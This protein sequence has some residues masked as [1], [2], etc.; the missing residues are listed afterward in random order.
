VSLAWGLWDQ[1]S[2]MTGGL[3][4]ADRAR[5]ARTGVRALP[6]DEALAQLDRALAG[7]RA[8][9]VPI[10]LDVRVLRAAGAE[11]VA[12]VLRALVP[13]TRPVSQARGAAEQTPP[14]AGLAGAA[15]REALLD[16]VCAHVATV[17]GHASADDVE[18]DRGFADLGFDSLM[19]VELRN[20]LAAV[21]GSRLRATL[22]FDFPT[23]D[24]LAR[25]LDEELPGEQPAGL[26]SA[27]DELTRLERAVA[28]L[29]DDEA[30]RTHL[31]GRLRALLGGLTDAAEVTERPSVDDDL[32]GASAAEVLQLLD[33]ELGTH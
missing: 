26:G 31:A 5:M 24:L 20:Q 23:P 25:H 10:G 22:T 27:R 9:V 2:D 6:A 30:E 13:A 8:A 32:A 1:A 15:R 18:T 7:D 19:A 14:W 3:T 12:P 11:A 17:L 4:D 28:E 33:N 16:L 21:T 29:G